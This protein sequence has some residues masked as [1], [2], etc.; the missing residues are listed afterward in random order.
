VVAA[1]EDGARLA[2]GGDL[3]LQH[4][5]AMGAVLARLRIQAGLVDV[6]TQEED[7]DVV[8]AESRY[9]GV[10]CV[11]HRAEHRV[12]VGVG[13]FLGQRGRARIAD[14]EDRSGDVRGIPAL[15]VGH[16]RPPGGADRPTTCQCEQAD[17]GPGE[18]LAV[19]ANAHAGSL[20][21]RI[22]PAPSD[23]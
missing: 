12:G 1:R 9:C 20:A 14:Q 13:A 11:A 23:Q 3:R 19:A 2:G 6:V 7:E 15:G 18:G 10:Y 17:E 5:L 8:P 21:P 22:R 16:R 4:A